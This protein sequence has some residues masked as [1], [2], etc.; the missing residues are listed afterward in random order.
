MNSALISISNP[1]GLGV[2]KRHTTLGIDIQ[3]S[4][5]TPIGEGIRVDISAD[6]GSSLGDLSL[7]QLISL[8]LPIQEIDGKKVSVGEKGKASFVISFISVPGDTY[9]ELSH[10]NSLIGFSDLSKEQESA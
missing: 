9:I 5:T 7:S 10:K 8:L 2:T 4:G 6:N 1:S 3:S